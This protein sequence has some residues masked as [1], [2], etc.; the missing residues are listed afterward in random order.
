[1]TVEQ[2]IAIRQT[3]PIEE[4]TFGWMGIK[5][6]QPHQLKRAQL[7]YSVVGRWAYWLSFLGIYWRRPWKREGDWRDNWLV[8]ANDDLVGDPIFVDLQLDVLPVYTAA[9]GEGEW[10]PILLASSFRGFVEALR[11]IDRVSAGR[12]YPVALEENPLPDHERTTVLGAIQR[13]IGNGQIGYWETW[14]NPS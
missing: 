11:E 5:V 4:V 9:H 14:L 3:S 8:I 7:G 10:E 1:M 12:T 6:Y 13:A 2:Y